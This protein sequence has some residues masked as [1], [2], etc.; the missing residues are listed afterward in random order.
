MGIHI[1]PFWCC[2]WCH[3]SLQ[4]CC[5][6]KICV[7]HLLID[8]LCS[9]CHSWV[10]FLW[11]VVIFCSPLSPLQQVVIDLAEDVKMHN[12]IPMLQQW[13]NTCQSATPVSLVG[14]CLMDRWLSLMPFQ[15]VVCTRH[16]CSWWHSWVTF[17]GNGSEERSFL[18]VHCSKFSFDLVEDGKWTRW[19]SM[20]QQ[21]P[22]WRFSTRK[23]TV[24]QTL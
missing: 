5:T 11:P 15:F 6:L 13:S 7:D 19:N 12:M 16:L 18:L 3:C 21:R 20:L 17:L 9:Q 10:T 4:I 22:L 23:T 14:Q 8:S 24:N 2:H 1:I